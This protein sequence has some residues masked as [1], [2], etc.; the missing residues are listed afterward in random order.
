QS[1]ITPLLDSRLAK[2]K[3]FSFLGKEFLV[4]SYITPTEQTSGFFEGGTY[5]TRSEFQK[6]IAANANAKVGYGLFSGEMKAAYSS[7]YQSSAE[8]AY[9]YNNSFVQLARLQLGE[10]NNF[11]SESFIKRIDGLPS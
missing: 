1:F 8:F 7:E 11:R 6:S 4:P 9:T 2:K 10:F 3:T 5:M